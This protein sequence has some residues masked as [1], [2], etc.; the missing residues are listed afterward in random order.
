MPMN[1]YPKQPEPPAQIRGKST[2]L[3][4][5]GPSTRE[6]EPPE[7]ATIGPVFRTKPPKYM[8]GLPYSTQTLTDPHEHSAYT[9]G[10]SAYMAG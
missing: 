8:P 7:H 1:T 6:R 2:D 3:R 10:P 5:G 4:T 9:A